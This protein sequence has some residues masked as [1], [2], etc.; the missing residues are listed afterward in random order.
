V[1]EALAVYSLDIRLTY[2]ELGLLSQRPAVY[3]NR[4]CISHG[5][6]V[7]ITFEKTALYV[8]AVLA[9]IRAS[10]C[11]VSLDSSYLTPARFK[12]II[13]LCGAETVLVTL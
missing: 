1:T 8:V 4:C 12:D 9:I 13:H 7:L 10:G 2:G 5:K 11:F 3:L 6:L